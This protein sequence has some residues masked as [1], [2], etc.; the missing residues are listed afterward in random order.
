VELHENSKQLC[1]RKSGPDVP[2]EGQGGIRV[3]MRGKEIAIDRGKRKGPLSP[4]SGDSSK[5]QQRGA[6]LKK[7]KKKKKERSNC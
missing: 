2:V 3:N 4:K 1:E 7:K 6:L 5:K